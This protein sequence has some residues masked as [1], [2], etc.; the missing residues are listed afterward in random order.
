[1]LIFG[2]VTNS[3]LSTAIHK[4]LTF[5]ASAAAAFFSLIHA[6]NCKRLWKKFSGK[7][8]KV[9]LADVGKPGVCIHRLTLEVRDGNLSTNFS[10][11]AAGEND[12]Y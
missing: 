8:T 4:S 5:Q 3:G 12:A 1:M 6:V 9:M 10:G 2:K 7:H 11:A